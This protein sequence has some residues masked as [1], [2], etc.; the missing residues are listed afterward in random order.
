MLDFIWIFVYLHDT[1]EKSFSL[2][3]R[4]KR[5]RL[6]FQIHFHIP[7][8]CTWG[9]VISN[10]YIFFY[11]QIFIPKIFKWIPNYH[12]VVKKR[13]RKIF[14]RSYFYVTKQ[15]KCLVSIINNLILLL[16]WQTLT[17]LKALEI[18]MWICKWFQKLN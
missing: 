1:A 13:L 17:Q 10:I 15:K 7:C 18:F 14:A 16:K 5:K 11:R 12:L 4:T 9:P 8:T 6:Y 2:N 3:F